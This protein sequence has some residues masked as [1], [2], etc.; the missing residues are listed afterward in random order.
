MCFIK[1]ATMTLFLVASSGANI[2]A[3]YDPYTPYY[4][5]EDEF[6]G[7]ILEGA[8]AVPSIILPPSILSFAP[9]PEEY[10]ETISSHTAFVGFLPPDGYDQIGS[11]SALKLLENSN[12]RSNCN[13][14]STVR[15]ESTTIDVF[16]NEVAGALEA[17]QFIEDALEGLIIFNYVSAV[18]SIGILFEDVTDVRCARVYDFD[19]NG[20]FITFCKI[21]I[22]INSNV[23]CRNDRINNLIHEILH[24]LGIWGHSTI[25]NTVMTLGGIMNDRYFETGTVDD[26]SISILKQ[27]YSLPAGTIIDRDTY[28][29][30][31]PSI[32][33]QVK[34]NYQ[35]GSIVVSLGTPV[36]ITVSLDPG[37][38]SAQAADWWVV[39][40][41]P[42]GTFNY[43]NLSRGSMV[44]GLFPTHQGPL[45]DLGTTQLLNSSDLT[46]GTHTFYFG[47]DL[48]MNGSLD[49]DSIYYDWVS[50]NVTG[51]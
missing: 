21:G 11:L 47:V 35:N 37:N 25:K 9:C 43:Y 20:S 7:T 28:E 13:W 34:A 12:I 40:S 38:L 6:K 46:V 41:T 16:L 14:S 50:V 32:Y 48:N 22:N 17:C 15:W 18:P 19:L 33:A 51:P 24:A 1:I 26:V 5:V 10:S 29:I 39:E 8:N 44:P 42:S 45:V 30:T 36:S 31:D 4:F 27:L 3:F 2:L 49:M 23:T